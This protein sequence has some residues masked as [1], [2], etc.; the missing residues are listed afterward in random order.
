MKMNLKVAYYQTHNSHRKQFSLNKAGML[1]V[2]LLIVA[3]NSLMALDV[4][5]FLNWKSINT[6]AYCP[7][8]ANKHLHWN[9]FYQI[10]FGVDSLA[11]KD[12]YAN[13]EL[14]SRANFFDNN[15]E[16]Y[17]CD[18]VYDENNWEIMAG[19]LPWGYGL[20][21]ALY[22]YSL[23]A[24]DQDQFSY[25]ATRL[26]RVSFGH[27]FSN[28]LFTFAIGGNNHNQS[29]E[30]LTY[31][32]L[33]PHGSFSISEEVRAQDNHWKTPVSISSINTK[34]QAGTI[35]LN[36]QVAVS[37]LPNYENTEQHTTS[38]GLLAANYKPTDLTELFLSAEYIEVE[39]S[40]NDE[41]RFHLGISHKIDNI[42]FNPFYYLDYYDNSAFHRTGL[43]LD[44]LF[45]QNQ[46]VGLVYYL[47]GSK[48]NKAKHNFGIQAQL[49]IKV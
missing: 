49:G 32:L 1:L 18:F 6:G 11:Y 21:N 15:V 10:G 5:F 33:K 35:A 9:E 8:Q 2:L 14:R 37:Y 16:V 3:C 38:Y 39:P 17:K 28:Q 27:Y 40:L 48:I 20:P 46:K 29:I 30:I 19:S 31:Q 13:L 45:Y 7:N 42:F 25:Q 44:Y 23:V 41:Q 12:L 26:N 47:E 4:P 34:I 43:S 22:T 24:A 36:A